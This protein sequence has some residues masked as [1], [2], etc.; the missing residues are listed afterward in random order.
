MSTARVVARNTL[1]LSLA[2]GIRVALGLALILFIANRFGAVWQGKFSI[3]LAFLNIFQVLASFGLPRLITREVARDHEAANRYFWSGL[4]AQGLTTL[5]VMAVMAAV[6][7]LMPYPS[8]TKAMLWLAV[9]ALPLF[10]AY[11]VAGALLRAHER[12]QYLVYAEVLSASAQLA[13][14]VVLLGAGFGVMAL[15]IIRIAGLGLAAVTVVASALALRYI[16]RPA[17]AASFAKRLLRESTDFFGLAGFDALLHRLDVLVL[18][19]VAGEAATGLYD[20]AFQIVKVLMTL[21]LSFTDAAYPTLSRLFVRERARFGL[22]AGKAMQ[23]GII[24]LLPVAAGLTVLAPQIIDFLYRRPAYAASADILAALA[25]A[26][27]FYF[28]SIFLTR[29]LMAG[30]RARAAFWVTATMVAL[31]LAILAGLSAA[32]GPVGTAWGLVLVYLLGAS[33]AWRAARGMKI[34]FGT[35]CLV[36]PALAA[37]FM[38]ATLYL[39]PELTLWLAIPL[40]AGLYAAFALGLRVFDREDL[41]LLHSLMGK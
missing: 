5:G 25:W 31:G 13:V 2:Q 18:S 26:T 14:A 1:F 16:G 11:S 32:F 35:R 40:G 20:A 39:L 8:D 33:L 23:Y 30:D 9:L 12:M 10:T 24:L 27:P 36:R 41:A 15:A 34:G 6:V 17:F 3:L 21:I 7:A 4:A 38:A 22:T 37:T 29:G 28:L 19:V